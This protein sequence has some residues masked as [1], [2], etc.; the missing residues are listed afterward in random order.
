MELQHFSDKHPLIFIE[1]AEG[2]FQCDGCLEDIKGSGYGC[3]ECDFDLHPSCAKLPRELQHPIH[4]KFP[5]NLH[6]T[7]PYDGR[8]CTCNGCNLPCR[9]FVY[10]CPIC[11]FDLDI[12][13]ASLP[14][15][16]KAENHD[17]PWTLFQNSIPFTCNACGKKGEGMPYL[18]GECGLWV[19]HNCASLPG[20]VKHIRHKHPLN[21]TYSLKDNHFKHRLCQLCVKVVDTKY[22]FYYCS[23]CNYVAHV[24][25]AVDKEGMD[26][27]FVRESVMTMMEEE[28][29]GHDEFTNECYI[30]I[31]T[32]V[33]VDKVE[34]PIEIKHFTHEHS[35][36]LTTKFEKDKICD[37]CIRS[38]FPPFYCCAQCNFFLH[39][40]CAELPH[41]KQ[42]P[43]H[44][45][46][47]TLHPRRA[48]RNFFFQCNACKYHT[49]GFTYRCDICNFT[50]DVPC[51]L[52]S[53]MLT[54][55]GHEHTLILSSTT[56]AEEC[57]ACNSKRKIFRCTEC[58]FTLDFGCATLP[59]TVGYKQHEHPFTLRYTAEDD[60]GE[61]YCDI[62]EEE[63]DP[64]LWFYYCEE[65]SYPAH[66]KCIFEWLLSDPTAGDFRNVKFGSTYT[67]TVHQHLLTL[68]HKTKDGPP[69]YKCGRPCNEMFFECA[70][71]NFSFHR[72]CV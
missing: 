40:T 55:V 67:S 30:V 8:T 37:G 48:S 25:C 54:H 15:T 16:I 31:K 46:S 51:S 68:V 45:H 11:K 64:K 65:C 28:D 29:L 21:L 5:L 3:R 20:I 14:L 27:T 26:E 62:C 59:Q 24:D 61:Y 71:C 18:C 41:K 72:W 63:R 33:G 39:K 44:Q 53:D 6:K 17:H 66:P 50:L 35:L 56:N 52:L 43:L 49:N 12:K 7:P 13:C 36:Q 32:K 57:S 38:I 1:Q 23:K 70:T 69:C 10:H 4:Q 42:H 22:G 60:S 19:H 2:L 58:E 34:I 47:L 9:S